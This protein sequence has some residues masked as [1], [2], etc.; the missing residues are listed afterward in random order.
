M[1]EGETPRQA[2]ADLSSGLEEGNRRKGGRG[3][4]LS[5]LNQR[6]A[7]T[8]QGG[9]LWGELPEFQESTLRL[10]GQHH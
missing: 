5:E 1:K 8:R 7:A 2:A 3:G 4:H 10:W 6:G 9:E